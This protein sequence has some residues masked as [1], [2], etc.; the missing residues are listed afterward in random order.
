[1]VFSGK[2]RKTCVETRRRRHYSREQALTGSDELTRH[3]M[4]CKTCFPAIP[5]SRLAHPPELRIINELGLELKSGRNF[6]SISIG[7]EHHAFIVTVSGPARSVKYGVAI[8]LEV[9]CKLVDKTL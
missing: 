4:R 3:V 6:D 2:G 9:L 5:S 8:V 1:M 7:V